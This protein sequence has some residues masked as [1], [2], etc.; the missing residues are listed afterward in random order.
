[1]PRRP[2]DGARN[3]VSGLLFCVAARSLRECVRS[4]RGG[5]MVVGYSYFRTSLYKLN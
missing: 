1:V 2:G 3:I 5:V 4:V